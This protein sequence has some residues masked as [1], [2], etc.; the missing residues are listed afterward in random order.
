MA[1]LITDQRAMTDMT[2]LNLYS[3]TAFSMTLTPTS[4]KYSDT[5]GGYVLFKGTGISFQSPGVPDTA[6]ITGYT[7]VLSGIVAQRVSGL[8]LGPNEFEG[9]INLAN[10]G[11]TVTQERFWRGNDKLYGGAFNDH[12]TGR[13]GND[14][15]FGY[16]E[17]DL[18]EGGKGNDKLYGGGG[19]DTLKGDD[20]ADLLDASI[21]DDVL[22]GGTGNDTLIGGSGYDELSGG[23]G[24]DRFVFKTRFDSPRD[25]IS[26]QKDRIFDFQNGV[27]KLDLSLIDARTDLVGNQA[28]KFIGTAAF[29]HHKGEVRYSI[30]NAT[31][32]DAD[33]NGDGTAEFSLILSGSHKMTSGDFYL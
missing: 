8:D 23:A 4:V 13:A 32:V 24:T 6:S 33:L 14:E 11:R 15:L 7:L 20:G 29:T 27:D 31:R 12:L 1:T 18:L 5:S 2:S 26:N 22:S 19:N 17:T 28:F 9:L 16:G 21:G 30:S 10:P 3:L 25:P